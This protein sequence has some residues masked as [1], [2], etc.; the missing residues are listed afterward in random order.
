M[1]TIKQV[2]DILKQAPSD[3]PVHY[4]YFRC[5]PTYVDSWRGIYA[6]AALGWAPVEYKNQITAQ[7]LIKKLEYSLDKIYT[8]WKGGDYC[9]NKH[10]P[11]HIDNRGEC[12]NTEIDK[13]TFN[14][15]S[16]TIH[17]INE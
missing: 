7:E 11:L 10:T 16:V 12:T 15:Y 8:G 5:V 14:E 6:E 13:I 9:Y 17:L 4:S 3:A 2:L 1:K